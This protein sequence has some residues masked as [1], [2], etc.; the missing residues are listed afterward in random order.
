MFQPA[1][2]LAQLQLLDQFLQYL[3]SHRAIKSA[4]ANVGEINAFWSWTSDAHLIC[5][6]SA[7]CMVF[8]ADNENN[9]THWKMV[10]EQDVPMIQSFRVRL[11]KDLRLSTESW[12][13][14]H[15]TLVRFRN[16]YTAHRVANPPV[17]PNLDLAREIVFAYDSWVRDTA[18]PSDDFDYPPL[19]DEAESMER[20]LSVYVAAVM[21]SA[22]HLK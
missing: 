11:Q 22:R 14:Y 3:A 5:A 20:E 18:R 1:I 7:W 9:Q 16:E 21:D 6:V 4:P 19:R 17:V 15:R 13:D 10:F 2:F 8:G 12:Q